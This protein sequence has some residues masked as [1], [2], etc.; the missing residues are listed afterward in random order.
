MADPQHTLSAGFILK[1]N[2]QYTITKTLNRGGFGIT[3]HAEAEFMDHNIPQTGYYAIKEFFPEGLCQRASDQSVEPLDNKKAQFKEAMEEFKGEADC[4]YGLH[5]KG[6]VPVNE[7]IESNGTIYYVM[8]YLPGQSLEDYVSEK[9]GHLDEQEACS[10]VSKVGEALG[11][12]HQKS[13]LHLDVKPDNIMMSNG[14]PVLIDF[15]SFRQF[16]TSG[17]ISS[18]RRSIM[19]TDGYSPE[20]QYKGISTFSPQ[21][22]VYALGATLFFMLTGEQPVEASEVSKKWLYTHL[23]DMLSEHVAEALGGAMA[24]RASDR[25]G[26]VSRFIAA[27][28]GRPEDSVKPKKKATKIVK[29]EGNGG[30][31]NGLLWAGIAAAAVLAFVAAYMFLSKPKTTADADKDNSAKTEV[32]DTTEAAKDDTETKLA[33]SKQSEPAPQPTSTTEKSADTPQ[34]PSQQTPVQ[35]PPIQQ[36]PIQQPPVQQPPVQQPPTS[37]SST[38][39]LNLGYA[40][41]TGGVKGGKPDGKGTMTFNSSHVI[42]S[43][44]ADQR[45]ASPGD[46]VEGR[47]SEGHLV[48]GTWYKADGG[49]E[50]LNIGMR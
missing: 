29:V 27:L 23:P 31:R 6:I 9:G 2:H 21:A 45:T 42:E 46:R 22:D 1:G 40:T 18:K 15:G 4:L 24:R 28:H 25:T 13:I 39:S 14:L 44:D 34:Q 16:N 11:Y 19:V 50:K 20:E 48:F 12:L 47:Y 41:W 43:W 8:K 37:T 7:V 5:H 49:T 26:S 35:Q 3:Y 32:K 36:P 10:I 33:D 30:K 17:D 38:G